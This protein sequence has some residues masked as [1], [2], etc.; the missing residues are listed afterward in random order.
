MDD[1]KKNEEGSDARDRAENDDAMDAGGQEHERYQ[2]RENDR[3]ENVE[4]DLEEERFMTRL[5]PRD[6]KPSHYTW[7]Y[8]D[9]THS[10]DHESSSEREADDERELS[11]QDDRDDAPLSTGKYQENDNDPDQRTS[12][13]DEKN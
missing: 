13:N 4:G 12:S 1:L 2:R 3:S 8:K 5:R 6:Y 7:G 10:T 11:H 9:V